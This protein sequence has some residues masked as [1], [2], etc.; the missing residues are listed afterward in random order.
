MSQDIKDNIRKAT[1]LIPNIHA[2]KASVD[3]VVAIT[4]SQ[5]KHV[6]D[7]HDAN[8]A[9]NAIQI[10]GTA[11]T[12]AL[13]PLYTAAA[14]ASFGAST[15]QL[16][17]AIGGVTVNAFA[18]VFTIASLVKEVQQWNHF[19]NMYTELTKSDTI[20]SAV[21]AA[22]AQMSALENIVNDPAYNL[23]DKNNACLQVIQIA[24]D[25]FGDG[26]LNGL[27]KTLGADHGYSQDDIDAAINAIQNDGAEVGDYVVAYTLVGASAGMGVATFL[28]FFFSDAAKLGRLG[29][30]ALDAY[31]E[32]RNFV[33]IWGDMSNTSKIGEQTELEFKYND[34]VQK[35]GSNAQKAQSSAKTFNAGNGPIVQTLLAIAAAMTIASGVVQILIDQF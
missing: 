33:K 16:A 12:V 20:V 25:N 21:D 2:L 1:T 22:D 28:A 7:V 31:R 4:P 30:V 19:K 13:I 26:K 9:L 6:D 29:Q 10:A 14:V 27:I 8:I 23:T 35:L 17:I 11:A 34:L 18:L 32:L 5:Y 24:K 3:A 15:V